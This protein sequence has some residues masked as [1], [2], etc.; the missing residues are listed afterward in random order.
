MFRMA[1]ILEEG[2][3]GKLFMGVYKVLRNDGPWNLKWERRKM[4]EC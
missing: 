3:G 1:S 4:R 2:E